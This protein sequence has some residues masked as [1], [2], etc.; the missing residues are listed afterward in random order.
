MM[1]I[2]KPIIY[3]NFIKEGILEMVRRSNHDNGWGVTSNKAEDIEMELMD[4]EK[5]FIK[6]FVLFTSFFNI[7]YN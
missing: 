5:L 3:L 7:Q 6:Q 4:A 2:E 1:Y